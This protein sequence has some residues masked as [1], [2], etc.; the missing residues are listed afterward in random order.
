MTQNKVSFLKKLVALTMGNKAGGEKKDKSKRSKKEKKKNKKRN[1]TSSNASIASNTSNPSSVSDVNDQKTEENPDD[2]N[3]QNEPDNNQLDESKINSNSNPNPPKSSPPKSSPP[4]AINTRLS[5]NTS[6]QLGPRKS[7]TGSPRNSPRG[8]P[9]TGAPPPSIE[10]F[11][12]KQEKKKRKLPSLPKFGAPLEKQQLRQLNEETDYKVDSIRIHDD[13]GPIPSILILLKKYLIKFH[14]Y[15]QVGIFANGSIQNI[16]KYHNLTEDIKE[17][18]DDFAFVEG[19]VSKVDVYGIK[20]LI[21]TNKIAQH[22]FGDYGKGE[23]KHYAMIFAELIKLWLQYLQY[24]LLNNLP[25]TF[26]DDITDTDL[27]TLEIEKVPE[28]NLSAFLFV[29]DICVEV[30]NN[31]TMNQMTIKRM[32]NVIGPYLYKDKDKERNQQLKPIL[33][34]FCAIAIEW[35]KND[36]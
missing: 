2:T 21:E 1:K 17:D 16:E 31:S 18:E 20:Q 25:S 4:T 36:Y 15:Q 30:S 5:P 8:S 12:A 14:G 6:P 13:Y 33:A 7:P 10:S 22:K 11:L 34:R 9:R 27:L 24:G 28:P 26:F 23:E 29:M 3:Q 32:G 35:R 19:F